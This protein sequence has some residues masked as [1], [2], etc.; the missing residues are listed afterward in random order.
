MST[1]TV[2][3]SETMP[4]GLPKV[5]GIGNVRG[6]DAMIEKVVRMLAARGLAQNELERMAGLSANRISK[7]KNKQG[8]PTARNIYRIARALGVPVDWLC[9]D[10]A[11]QEPPAAVLDDREQTLLRQIRLLGVDEAER[12]LLAVGREESRIVALMRSLELDPLEVEKAIWSLR[13][14]A[15]QTVANPDHPELKAIQER[16]AAKQAK[17]APPPGKPKDNA[18]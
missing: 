13:P 18:G 8:E 10:A 5:L 16:I 9:D 2:E 7:W 12:R 14:P 17:P 3:I 6:M 15:N 4:R 1:E 11:P